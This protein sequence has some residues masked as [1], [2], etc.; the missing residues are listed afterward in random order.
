MNLQ[1]GVYSSGMPQQNGHIEQKFAT[2]FNWECAML[3][4]SKFT[5]YLQNGLWAKAANTNMLLENNL[6]A[7]KR[8]LSS[9]QQFFGN[10]E[11]SILT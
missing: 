10:G 9:F 1:T 2:L 4:G 5:T 6:I 7:P 3:N 11:R 8:N